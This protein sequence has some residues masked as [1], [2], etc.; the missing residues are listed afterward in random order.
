[1]VARSYIVENNQY[2]VRVPSRRNKLINR[3]GVFLMAANGGTPMNNAVMP[4]QFEKACRTFP[5]DLRGSMY[6]PYH[7]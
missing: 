3:D 7:G 1:M 5:A 4:E 6:E 2:Q